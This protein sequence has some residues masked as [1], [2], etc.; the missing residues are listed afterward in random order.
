MFCDK[1]NHST[2]CFV[3]GFFSGWYSEIYYS[4]CGQNYCKVSQQTRNR[5]TSLA[6][7]EWLSEVSIFMQ[8][9]KIP[10]DHFNLIFSEQEKAS[11][12]ANCNF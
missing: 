2:G 8:K 9:G 6:G 4:N 7:L 10:K 5:A 12:K 1:K 11:K 3:A